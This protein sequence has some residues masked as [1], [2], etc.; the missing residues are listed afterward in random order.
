MN[1]K[2]TNNAYERTV[3]FATQTDLAEC[4]MRIAILS[5]ALD[6][7]ADMTIEKCST[8]TLRISSHDSGGITARDEN[9]IKRVDELI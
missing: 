4:L 9:W 2:L 6:H 8:L 1:W 5:D 3:T 7:H